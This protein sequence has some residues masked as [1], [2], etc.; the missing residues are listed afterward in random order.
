MLIHVVDV[1]SQLFS[2]YTFCFPIIVPQVERELADSKVAAA[3]VPSVLVL[4]LPQL[5]L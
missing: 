4:L 1:V 5:L 2:H 3:R